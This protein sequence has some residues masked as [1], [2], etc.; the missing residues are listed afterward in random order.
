MTLS[1]SQTWTNSSSNALTIFGP[2]SN[3]GNA[4]SFAG[5]GN[6][7]V[8]GIFS[9][10]NIST[11]GPDSTI[12]I[13]GSIS[14]TPEL[15]MTYSGSA[16]G[17]FTSVFDNGSRL[18]A[19]DS[20]YSGGSLEVS[21]SAPAFSGS[22]TW[23]GSTGS[24][25]SASAN[26]TPNSVPGNGTTGTDKATFNN[27]A[28]TVTAI[29][30]D[31]NPNLA[32][33]NF[34]GTNYTL[35]GG[36]LTLQNN[37]GPSTVTVSGGAQTIASALRISAGILSVSMSNSSLLDITGNIMQDNSP[38]ALTLNGDGS[39]QLKLSGTDT[40]S[41]GTSVLAGTLVEQSNAG[42]PA[43]S[44]LSVGTELAM[45]GSPLAGEIVPVPESGTLA[46]LLAAGLSA[47]LLLRR[48]RMSRR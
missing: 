20:T 14:A 11:S 28:G 21:G 39:G 48:R 38:E 29:T 43:V 40:Y 5:S 45:F 41:G 33:L 44:N 37:S 31:I 16:S 23:N 3:N 12:N 24:S 30:L 17:Q 47:A 8:G 15:L 36:T 27:S 7:T 34:S 6:I 2:V 35:S 19:S 32:G 9:S 22:G 46:L 1:A 10:G 4:L 26:W 25:W 18:P 42:L 13:S